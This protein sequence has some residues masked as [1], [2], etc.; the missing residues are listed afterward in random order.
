MAGDG[1][2]TGSGTR[3][4]ANGHA[5]PRNGQTNASTIVETA[6]GHS[7]SASKLVETGSVPKTA[8]GTAE[9][10]SVKNPGESARVHETV[11]GSWSKTG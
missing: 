9:K 6:N 8:T 10:G 5:G 2:M 4:T 11:N 3:V 1:H 7:K